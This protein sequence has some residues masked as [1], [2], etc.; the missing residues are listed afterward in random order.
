MLAKHSLTQSGFKLHDGMNEMHFSSW[1]SKPIFSLHEQFVISPN[2]NKRF[3]YG[4]SQLLKSV[5]FLLHCN[6]EYGGRFQLLS[7]L[8]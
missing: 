3:S 1:H 7:A 5:Y 8:N 4:D 6:G 2:Q